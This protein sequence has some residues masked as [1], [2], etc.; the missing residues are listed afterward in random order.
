LDV[1]QLENIEAMR[2]KNNPEGGTHLP[3]CETVHR[4]GERGVREEHGGV[5]DASMPRH[6]R[7]LEVFR[8]QQVLTGPGSRFTFV[9]KD[10]IST[11]ITNCR[12]AGGVH[13]WRGVRMNVGLHYDAEMHILRGRVWGALDLEG[14]RN[15]A[16]TAAALARQTGCR[17]LLND[18]RDATVS[19]STMEMY[20]LPRV[21][22]GEGLAPGIKR[23]LLVRDSPEEFRFLETVFI[24]NGQQVRLFQSLDEGERW[25]LETPRTQLCRR[26]HAPFAQQL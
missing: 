20:M 11:V 8:F 1:V 7:G 21:V 14:V 6:W 16:S 12:G 2:V 17:K 24:N 19:A 5:C 9:A 18:L 3:V 15:M 26:H 25:L 22:D 13:P 23:A 4:G 10:S